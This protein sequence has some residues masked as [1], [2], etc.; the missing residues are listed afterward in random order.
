[1]FY[2]QASSYNDR[3]F[4]LDDEDVDSPYCDRDNKRLL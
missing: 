2:C 4:S 1:M 3:N